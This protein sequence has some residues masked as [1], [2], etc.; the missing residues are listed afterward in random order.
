MQMVNFL[1]FYLVSGLFSEDREKRLVA[2]I[3]RWSSAASGGA[4]VEK[5]HIV[6]S[7]YK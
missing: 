4:T 3:I 5:M 1:T 2:Q 7:F 6:K